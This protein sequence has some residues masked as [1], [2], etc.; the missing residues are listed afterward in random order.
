VYLS[1]D[2]FP[3]FIYLLSPQSESSILLSSSSCRT[4]SCTFSQSTIIKSH[5][6]IMSKSRITAQ[7]S[8]PRKKTFTNIA[9]PN[10]TPGR[11]AQASHTANVS[12]DDTISYQIINTFA[13]NP[14]LFLLSTVTCPSL[15]RFGVDISIPQQ[16][17]PIPPTRQHRHE[18]STLRICT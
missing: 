5:L 13:S 8:P 18:Q 16:P 1:R 17:T 10:R 4:E 15:A 9:L 12:H 2:Q 14:T 7:T 6:Y 3:L 11:P